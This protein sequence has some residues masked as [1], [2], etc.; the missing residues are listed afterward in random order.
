MIVRQKYA[1]WVGVLLN[2]I[3]ANATTQFEPTTTSQLIEH[4]M[5]PREKSNL[6]KGLRENNPQL[7]GHIREVENA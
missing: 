7:R 6:L 1:G 2:G 5:T 4:Q 3:C